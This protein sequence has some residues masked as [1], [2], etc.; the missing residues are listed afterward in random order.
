MKI[1]FQ[2]IP[3]AVISLALTLVPQFQGDLETFDP[4]LRLLSELPLVAGAV[5]L[6]VRL[7][8]KQQEQ[9]AALMAHFEQRAQAKDEFYQRLVTDLVQT[10]EELSKS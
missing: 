9:V 4:L 8:D 2:L 3:F 1:T 5:W 7:Q 6:V 10:I